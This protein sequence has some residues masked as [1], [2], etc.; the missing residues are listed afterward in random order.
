MS[1]I[2]LGSLRELARL[3]WL[4]RACGH[5]LACVLLPLLW[6]LAVSVFSEHY[7]AP[8]RVGVS[9]GL[10]LYYL[11]H[12]FVL[13]NLALIFVSSVK[14]RC[15]VAIA[16]TTLV[17]LYLAVGSYSHPLRGT[18]LAGLFASLMFLAVLIDVAYRA[19]LRPTASQPR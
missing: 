3:R 5:V 17:L 4:G 1:G 19:C 14:A 7:H 10:A 16:L 11:F 9:F 13:V 12:L 8:R 2:A 15:A 6:S 18:L